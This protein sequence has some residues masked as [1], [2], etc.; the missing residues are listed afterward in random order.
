MVLMGQ[1]NGHTVLLGDAG[2]ALDMEASTTME[3]HSLGS[4]WAF[5]HKVGKQ[6]ES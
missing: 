5:L 6:I 2:A 4:T 3:D 1:N